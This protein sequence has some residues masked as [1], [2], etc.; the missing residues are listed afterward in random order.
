VPAAH[1]GLRA[2]L[3]REPRAPGAPAMRMILALYDR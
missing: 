2:T 1:A 3:E